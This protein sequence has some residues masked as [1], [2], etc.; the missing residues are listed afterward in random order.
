M[1]HHRYF[2]FLV[3]L[4]AFWMGWR[5]SQPYWFTVYCGPPG[6]GV[7]NVLRPR[8]AR[9]EPGRQGYRLACDQAGFEAMYAMMRFHQLAAEVCTQN[10]A[11]AETLCTADGSPYR[12]R[13]AALDARGQSQV[14]EDQGDFC[15]VYDPTH[16]SCQKEGPRK[17][18]V[19]RPAIDVRIEMQALKSHEQLAE[20]YASLL[21][22]FE[23]RRP[24]LVVFKCPGDRS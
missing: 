17:G 11:N 5:Q 3:V 20:A 16:P 24:D 12:R 4:M 1:K 23:A 22:R 19:A 6:E 14:V 18:Y 15:W 21:Q 7:L 9:F 2:W 13:I 10:L 8:G